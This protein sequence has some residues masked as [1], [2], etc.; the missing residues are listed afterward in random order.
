[1]PLT[2]QPVA[3]MLPPLLPLLF[4]PPS[5]FS[6]LIPPSFFPPSLPLRRA[7]SGSSHA[8]S[9]REVATCRWAERNLFSQSPAPA[10]RTTN[11]GDPPDCMLL[12]A[13]D[14][15]VLCPRRAR[16]YV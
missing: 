6:H 12:H 4:S 7:G 5:L 14:L 8:C 2:V 9:P 13:L 11:M 15:G 3:R 1:M 16:C 10:I